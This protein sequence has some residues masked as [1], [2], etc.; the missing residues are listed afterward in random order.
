MGFG[1]IPDFNPMASDRKEQLLSF[2]TQ[3]TTVYGLFA[4]LALAATV[5]LP[6]QSSLRSCAVNTPDMA[7]MPVPD[8]SNAV[9]QVMNTTSGVR[10]R[11]PTLP[12]CGWRP[13]AIALQRRRS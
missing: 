10:P 3:K 5:K 11:R 4:L 7:N 13:R 8:T 2:L 9:I 6:T 1:L 12:S